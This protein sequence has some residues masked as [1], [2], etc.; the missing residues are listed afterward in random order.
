MLS[1]T[2]A[3]QVCTLLTG[4]HYVNIEALKAH[5]HHTGGEEENLNQ[6]GGAGSHSQCDLCCKAGAELE[7]L[8]AA[9][10]SRFK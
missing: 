4:M 8:L 3:D 1:L 7:L 9:E 6:T 10:N 2:I 5:S